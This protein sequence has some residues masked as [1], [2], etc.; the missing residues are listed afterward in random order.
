[1]S[2]I[3]TTIY[4]PL[5]FKQSMFSQ[6]RYYLIVTLLYLLNLRIQ[7]QNY[8]GTSVY[9]QKSIQ[10]DR[11]SLTFTGKDNQVLQ[12]LPMQVHIVL[13][14]NGGA[15]FSSLK[16]RESI[17][18]LNDDFIPTGFQFYMEKPVH[19]IKSSKYNEHTYDDGEQMMKENNLANVINV[20]IVS[21]PAGNCGYYTYRGD[22]VA[23]SKSCTSKNS[24][25]WAHEFGHYFSLPHT[26]VGWE[27]IDYASGSLAS[28]YESKVRG[29]IENVDRNGCSSRADDFCDTPAD[30]ISNRWGCDNSDS[31]IIVQVDLNGVKFK[32]D[33]SL[34]M[35]YSLDNCSSR[36][37][38]EQMSAMQNFLIQRRSDLLRT[39]QL[40]KLE[41]FDNASAFPIDSSITSR[42]VKFS[43][44]DV[45]NATSYIFQ[46]ARNPVFSVF[47]VNKEIN[48]N[49]I[50]VDS[51]LE[52][53]RY[54][55]R[56]IPMSLEDYCNP[57]SNHFT[58]LVDQ[59]V[60]SKNIE[61]NK[62]NIYPSILSTNQSFFI[63]SEESIKSN[64]LKF[65]NTN[66]ES[67]KNLLQLN[68]YGNI[69]EVNTQQLTQGIYFIKMNNQ[70][71]KISKIN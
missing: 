9:S 46:L 49:S 34:F 65:F 14:D 30:Y 51:L 69:I 5:E 31:S 26:F 44:K 25:T 6:K 35:S 19:Y 53:K 40:N 12:F 28:D 23:L 50:D 54:Y 68:S 22:A 18:T 58:F 60:A 21:S 37:S 33:G 20:Y 10:V 8:C 64:D 45:P 17:C 32:S 56:V 47:V 39:I 55:W 24:H 67:V 62:M 1:M 2:K 15:D 38:N 13:N 57:I 63:Q 11:H 42:K 7:A 70:I 29:R 16:L 36:F 4:L 61:N 71:Y 52:D 59:N 3:Q 66:G 43:W 41:N 48:T 27:G